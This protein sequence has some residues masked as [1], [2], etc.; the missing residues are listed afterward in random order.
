MS[1]IYCKNFRERLRGF[2]FQKWAWNLLL[3]S[4][5]DIFQFSGSIFGKS[6]LLIYKLV[7]ARFKPYHVNYFLTKF[8]D[9]R[10][11]FTLVL[12]YPK[13]I[14]PAATYE[15]IS[16]WQLSFHL[17]IRHKPSCLDSKH[18]HIYIYSTYLTLPRVYDSKVPNCSYLYL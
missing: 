18:T 8:Q 15:C 2:P 12:L 7:L 6:E 4:G 3:T 10:S 17:Y 14:I 13:F 5:A 1:I 9:P 11:P 16:T